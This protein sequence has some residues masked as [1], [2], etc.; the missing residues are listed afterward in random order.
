MNLVSEKI[1]E[2]ILRLLGLEDV[3]DIDAS[4]TKDIKINACTTTNSLNEE[5]SHINIYPNPTGAFLNSTEI[6]N[7]IEIINL[8]GTIIIKELNV[9]HV[10][11]SF[12][13]QGFYF[14]KINGR[15]V[16]RFLKM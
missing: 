11:V 2:R 10:D 12:L 8:Q 14:I 13:P 7:S 4:T 6:C 15:T 1:D 3:F 16:K 9:K 5:I